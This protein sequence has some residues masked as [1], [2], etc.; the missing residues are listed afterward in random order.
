ME[1]YIS[2]QKCFLLES[3]FENIQKEIKKGYIREAKHPKYPELR[4]Y[5][6]TDKCVFD[7]HWN[8]ETRICRGL[9][10]NSKTR[11]VI[12]WCIPKFFNK[13]EE[14]ADTISDISN[15]KI[16]LKEDG[17]MIQYTVHADYGL[18]VT[19]RGSFDSKYSNYVY[20]LLK[21][22][23]KNTQYG[24][25]RLSYICELCKDFEGDEG[26]IVTKHPEEKLVVW[27]ATDLM[28]NEVNIDVLERFLP[29][30]VT[31]AKEFTPDEAEEYLKGEVEGVVVRGN[32][33]QTRED[34]HFPHYPRV[35]VKTD[36]FLQMHRIISDCTQKRV[37]EQM[38][39][40]QS[41]EDLEG[42]P[43]EFMKQ[44]VHWE[45]EI[46]MDASIIITA[47]YNELAKRVLKS[48]KEI[49]LD[50]SLTK[51]FR[52]LIFTLKKK[53]HEALFK[54]VLKSLKPKNTENL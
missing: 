16:S 22:K 47:V 1:N 45:Q 5:N 26:I 33:I 24:F 7:G 8:E 52:A 42:I 2:V 40:G 3:T 10:I 9:V 50:E 14:Y 12:I 37:W 29:E 6:Y 48:D 44:M 46:L 21:D 17:Y 51:E 38:M 32:H 43:D 23:V 18:I 4:I 19:S 36:W 13:G 15:S 27:A 11:E 30:G 31:L 39:N 41:V 35:K 49:A 25:I 54:Q 28:G 34:L 20:E 53:G